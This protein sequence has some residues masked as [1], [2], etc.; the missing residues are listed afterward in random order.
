MDCR[1][2]S[3]L[4][5][6][7]TIRQLCQD[8]DDAQRGC[9]QTRTAGQHAPPDVTPSSLV[10]GLCGA[11]PPVHVFVSWMLPCEDDHELEADRQQALASSG[12][13]QQMLCWLPDAMEEYESERIKDGLGSWVEMLG[14][15]SYG[16]FKENLESLRWPS[17]MVTIFNGVCRRLLQGA[18]HDDFPTTLWRDGAPREALQRWTLIRL[19][20]PTEAAD[21]GG[22]CCSTAFGPLDLRHLRSAVAVVVQGRWI[23]ELQTPSV[24]RSVEL[25]RQRERLCF[26][27]VDHSVSLFSFTG[28]CIYQNPASLKK[29][30]DVRLFCAENTLLAA[31]FAG[32]GGLE[33]QM[34]ETIEAGGTHVGEVRSDDGR[35]HLVT[36]TAARDPMDGERCLCV[37]EADISL[38]KRMAEEKA[39]ADAATEHA[40]ADAAP[41]RADAERGMNNFL[42]HEVRNPL[43]V[44]V[45][46]LH[47]VESALDKGATG[48]TA[49]VRADLSMVAAS[50]AYVDALM[51]NVLD[52]NKF[53]AGK[54]DLQ[55][56][57]HS[58]LNDVLHP[59]V[60]ILGRHSESGPAISVESLEPLWVHV[61]ALRLKQV[62]VNLV[63][64]AIK[65]VPSGFVRIGARRRSRERVEIWCEDSGPGIPEGKGECLFDEYAQLN[66]HDQGTGVGLALC[67]LITEQMGGTISVVRGC[68]TCRGPLSPLLLHPARGHCPTLEVEFGLFRYRPLDKVEPHAPSSLTRAQDPTYRNDG[69][70]GP[71]ARFVLS[72]PL[73]AVEKPAAAP[74]SAPTSATSMA[75]PVCLRGPYTALVVDDDAAVRF[76]V[77]RTLSAAGVRRV[78][79]A[80]SGEGALEMVASRTYDVVIMDHVRLRRRHRHAAAPIPR[81]PALPPTVLTM[82]HVH[83]ASQ[84]MATSGGSLTGTEAIVQIRA[85]GSTAL[86]MGLSANDMEADML[87]SGTYLRSYPTTNELSLICLHIPLMNYLH[88]PLLDCLHIPLM[89]YLHG[90]LLD[91]L[92]IPLM[93]PL[94]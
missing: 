52:F 56:E 44:A 53:A 67:R 48:V 64:N 60:A 8:D 65:F 27:Y 82:R 10:R 33:S 81:P 55:P 51:T 5:T 34:R 14:K 43:S 30:G 11:G 89:N 57:R 75:R 35:W 50:L 39:R 49:A 93:T 71:G 92:H 31:V 77:R 16:A 94:C 88:G 83:R 26:R 17:S 15:K 32:D 18:P 37:V 47:F 23:D 85:M 78:E 13:G 73:A 70:H 21:G 24:L 25:V 66:S 28:A 90:P 42:A 1:Q 22:G 87:R 62:M 20:V 4:L 40:R 2:Q 63:K 46:G 29:N 79:E 59:V 38:Q 76:V 84:Y 45:G 6:A 7:D 80:E 69:P 68:A 72:L 91:C 36:C 58:L 3:D 74:A 12:V 54:I 86:I 9:Y 41:A 61:D 19:H